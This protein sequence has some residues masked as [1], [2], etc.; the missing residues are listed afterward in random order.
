LYF[1]FG[2]LRRL[3]CSGDLRLDNSLAEVLPIAVTEASLVEVEIVYF[4][5]GGVLQSGE[6]VEK[7]NTLPALMACLGF[8]HVSLLGFLIAPCFISFDEQAIRGSH[9]AFPLGRPASAL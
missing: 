5:N 8:G 2:S 6:R 3:R 1:E 4:S 7:I 9:A